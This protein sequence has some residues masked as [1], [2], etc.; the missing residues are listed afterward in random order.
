VEGKRGKNRGSWG[1]SRKGA[2]FFMEISLHVRTSPYARPVVRGNAGGGGGE[3]GVRVVSRGFVGEAGRWVR[4]G[5]GGGR[6]GG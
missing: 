5:G 1:L 2:G 4:G 3:G 6:F